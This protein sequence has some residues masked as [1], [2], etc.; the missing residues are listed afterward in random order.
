MSGLQNETENNGAVRKVGTDIRHRDKLAADV[1]REIPCGVL[2]RVSRLMTGD[3]DRRKRILV[4]NLRRQAERLRQRIIVI[5]KKSVDT[6]DSDV[7]DS[8]A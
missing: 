4:I 2:K 3:S 8:R 7:I 5:G 6:L 1:H